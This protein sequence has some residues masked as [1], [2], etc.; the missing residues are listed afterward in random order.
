LRPQP[1]RRRI[2]TLE[3]VSFFGYSEIEPLLLTKHTPAGHRVYGYLGNRYVRPFLTD[4]FSAFTDPF[5]I[6][7][8]DE[9]VR[10]GY[11][12]VARLYHR[13]SHPML[14]P[15]PAALRARNRVHYA[16]QSLR[17]RLEHPRDFVYTGRRGIDAVLIDDI[18]TT[19]M[20]LQ[21]AERVLQRHEV[22][23]LFALTV[24][25]ARR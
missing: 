1:Q 21:E 19:G 7:G 4:F 12:H 16:G 3:V 17:Y 2:G 10:S 15:Q 11:A 8:V 22:N 23:V 5:V 6:V 9:S 24:A 14:R 13:F 20:T 18:V 25:D